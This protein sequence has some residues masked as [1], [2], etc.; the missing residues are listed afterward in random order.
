M[1]RCDVY[2][3]KLEKAMA[4]PSVA[5]EDLEAAVK[6]LLPEPEGFVS[7]K[8]QEISRNGQVGVGSSMVFHKI[9]QT[10]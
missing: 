3:R 4:K 5:P 7:K 1:N 8:L 10:D 9:S 6:A 2:L